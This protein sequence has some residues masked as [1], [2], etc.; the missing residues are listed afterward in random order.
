SEMCIRD[1][2]EL[3]RAVMKA[4]PGQVVML[5]ATD[6]AAPR[7]V[8]EWALSVGHKVLKVERVGG[9][10]QIYVEVSS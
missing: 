5:V 9:A 2:L 1:S 6:P 3:A 8:E 10:Y 7:D 4:S